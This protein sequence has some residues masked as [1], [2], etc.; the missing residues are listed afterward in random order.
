MSLSGAQDD[1]RRKLHATA[2]DWLA[3]ITDPDASESD[4]REW[5]EWLGADPVHVHAYE[6]MER[7]WALSAQL[8][9]VVALPQAEAGA[10]VDAFNVDVRDAQVIQMP[11]PVPV[12]A[13]ARERFRAFAIAASVAVVVVAGFVTWIVQ[14]S[15][16]D[17]FE[18]ATSE[19]RSL[20]LA[21]GS[22][23]IL[24]A[25]TRVDVNL[26]EKRRALELERGVAYFKVAHDTSRP[27]VV[28]GH[29]HTIEAV[30]TAFAVDS[31]PERVVVTVT[32]GTVRV[33]RSP[34]SG[35]AGSGR[36]SMLIHAGQRASVD[37][38]GIRCI[39]ISDASGTA[40]GWRDGRLE[41]LREE[42]RFVIADVN[43]YTNRKIVLDGA[44]IGA[45]EFTGTV[46][47]EHL[48]EWLTTL[49]GSFPLK[50]ANDDAQHVVLRASGQAQL[51]EQLAAPADGGANESH[52]DDC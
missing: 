16:P 39:V 27:F 21:D 37:N 10:N 14:R 47:L 48:D 2:A 24:G 26:G 51:A 41:Y 3:R 6:K 30:G 44:G 20:K 9:P 33:R 35:I 8:S 34:T 23:V 29:G 49:P 22:Q 11:T 5:Q 13:P 7:V 43:R 19:Q 1:A 52:E 46:F 32:E 38:S 40:L 50:I 4:F 18:T 25:E 42:L 36:E 28:S 17:V 15:V 31:K 12:T 45:L